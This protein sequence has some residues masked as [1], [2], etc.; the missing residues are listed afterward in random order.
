MHQS[1]HHGM[2]LWDWAGLVS[3][4]RAIPSRSR[5]GDCYPNGMVA[6]PHRGNYLITLYYRGIHPQYRNLI[7]LTHYVYFIHIYL[8]P[9]L[10]TGTG[11]VRHLTIH[12]NIISQTANSSSA[13]PTRPLS[14]SPP[15]LLPAYPLHLPLPPSHY[16]QHR[17]SRV[18]IAGEFFALL[19]CL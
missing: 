19:L 9:V 2:V 17:A 5:P 15:R 6:S 16:P 1:R 10:G 4:S 14:P 18:I 12:K 11:I 7:T 3:S 8:L 13:L